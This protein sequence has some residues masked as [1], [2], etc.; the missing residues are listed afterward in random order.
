MSI[1]E[2][3]R[4]RSKR[5]AQVYVFPTGAGPQR[6]E[7]GVGHG[8][9]KREQPSQKPHEQH[10]PRVGHELSDENRNEEDAAANDVGDDNGRRIERSET[11]LERRDGV[12]GHTRRV[13][14]IWRSAC[15][16]PR[17]HR[18]FPIGS[19]RISFAKIWILASTNCELSS[20]CWRDSDPVY[21][22]RLDR[23]ALRRR[24]RRQSFAAGDLHE[25]TLPTPCPP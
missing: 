4:Q 9:R 1:R 6:G 15:G 13:R 3:G 11:T 5:L 8:S 17:I 19:T 10:G 2:K 16:A 14:I 23:L 18:P 24:T 12:S 22:L 7:L 20:I 25:G 21:Q